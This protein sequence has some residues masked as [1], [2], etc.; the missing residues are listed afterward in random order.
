[1]GM[2]AAGEMAGGMAGQ[3]VGML[4]FMVMPYVVLFGIGGGLLLVHR[5]NRAAAEPE[6]GGD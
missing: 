2:Q 3:M 6:A 1:M 4:F 5:R